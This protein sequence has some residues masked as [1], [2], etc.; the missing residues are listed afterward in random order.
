MI[1]N[2]LIEIIK[3]KKN[4]NTQMIIVIRKMHINKLIDK[5]LKPNKI[6]GFQLNTTINKL[7]FALIIKKEIILKYI[8]IKKNK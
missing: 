2:K 4:L 1:G 7:Y 8:K 6:E 5:N 3:I